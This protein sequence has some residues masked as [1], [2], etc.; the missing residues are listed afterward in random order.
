MKTFKVLDLWKQRKFPYIHFLLEFAGVNIAT[1]YEARYD[2]RPEKIE[3]YEPEPGR[4]YQ[5]SQ[6]GK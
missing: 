5:G 1:S 4:T 2:K 6:R 3:V